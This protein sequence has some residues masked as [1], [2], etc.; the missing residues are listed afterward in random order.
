MAPTSSPECL[1]DTSAA[2]ASS[3]VRPPA[4]GATTMVGGTIFPEKTPLARDGHGVD[5]VEGFLE[6][7]VRYLLNNLARA[8]DNDAF[9]PLV[10]QLQVGQESRWCCRYL[11]ESK[12]CP[13]TA[14]TLCCE[15]S[16]IH[17]GVCVW[18]GVLLPAG[19][20]STALRSHEILLIFCRISA[21][22]HPSCRGKIFSLRF[23][24]FSTLFLSRVCTT[25]GLMRQA[26]SWMKRRKG[27]WRACER[28]C[29]Y[30]QI[31]LCAWQCAGFT[32]IFFAFWQNERVTGARGIDFRRNSCWLPDMRNHVQFTD[33]VP[34]TLRLFP[35]AWGASN[36]SSQRIS[37]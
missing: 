10:E 12:T 32:C 36:S 7:G 14:A 1:T 17:M 9:A 15:Y 2:H 27:E 11:F 24:L 35:L 19:A 6:W 26:L 30:V 29:C 31:A 8:L 5:L 16:H 28:C 22:A 20:L 3:V 4:E 37:L 34:N 33:A 25:Y 18:S 21:R 13:R 23:S